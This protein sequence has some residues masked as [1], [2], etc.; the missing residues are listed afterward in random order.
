MKAINM[1]RLCLIVAM[2]VGICGMV[3]HVYAQDETLSPSGQFIAKYFD[4]AISV[5]LPAALTA[6]GVSY[7]GYKKS[8]LDGE[9]DKTKLI[10]TVIAAIVAS[11]LTTGA[12]MTYEDTT[13][14]LADGF[15]T[16]VLYWL[17]QWLSPKLGFIPIKNP[18]L[19]KP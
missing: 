13:K 10:Y 3:N 4:K 19:P 16:I 14:Y 1:I 5:I 17:A 15:V 12:G 7:L 8:H 18:T 11:L 2:V 6:A 9:Y